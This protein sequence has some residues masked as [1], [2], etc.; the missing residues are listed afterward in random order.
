MNTGADTCILTENQMQLLPFKLKIRITNTIL[1]RYE[2]SRITNIKATT[3][4][5]WKK[6][7]SVIDIK[8]R[9]SHQELDYHSSLLCTFN[10]PFKRYRFKRLPFGLTI[11]HDIFQQ[12]LDIVFSRIKNV[13]GIMDDIL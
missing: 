10:M 11:S 13:M 9:Y 8:K 4:T 2:C 6:C 7:Y 3:L 5:T 1:T 12:N